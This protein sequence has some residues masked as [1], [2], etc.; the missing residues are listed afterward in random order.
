MMLVVGGGG[1]V[2]TPY[3]HNQVYRLTSADGQRIL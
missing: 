3:S 2:V 1:V